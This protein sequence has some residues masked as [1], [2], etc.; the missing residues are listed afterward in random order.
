MAP[1][2]R[3]TAGAGGVS[4]AIALFLPSLSGGGAERNVLRLGAALSASGYTV[5]VVVA[6]ARGPNRAWVPDDVELVDLGARRA[7]TALV[8]L[9]RF[10]RRRRP[11]VLVSAL[12]SAN[13]VALAAREL[14]RVEVPVVVSE[15]NTITAWKAGAE[16]FRRR[17]VIPWL[18][19]RLY[20]RADRLVAV[21]DGAARDLARFLDLP[22]E[23]V[24]AIP[25]PVVDPRLTQLAADPL[26]TRWDAWIGDAPL[27]LSVG[28]LTRQKDHGLLL[29][30]YA[31]VRQRMPQARLAILGTGDTISEIERLRDE[32]E[33]RDTVLLPGFDDNPYRWM[34]RAQVVALT[35]RYE[36]LP[37]VLIEALACGAR[38]VATDCPS[39][40]SEILAGG[41]WGQLVPV[42]DVDGFADALL[43][44]LRSGRWPAPPTAALD[45]Y[46]V[47][48]VADEYR[49]LIDPMVAAG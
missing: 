29:R 47:E 28:R 1:T 30:A 25:N 22:E 7:A 48:R 10:L 13:V 15:R 36:G 27:V 34:A 43:A 44:S 9:A 20:P 31:V 16:G 26:P 17:H 40:P 23:D 32:L 11:G 5:V 33:L 3:R 14:A 49:A 6:D 21:S 2:V 46:R 41:R 18:V 39:G 42:G 38:V 19:R 12:N 37:T 45:R 4:D 35:S 24:V 8:P